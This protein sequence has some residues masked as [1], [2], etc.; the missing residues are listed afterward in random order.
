MLR[1]QTQRHGT[2]STQ[3]PS[4]YDWRTFY[5]HLFDQLKGRYEKFLD[6]L[7]AYFKEQHIQKQ[8]DF[9]RNEDWMNDEL[10]LFSENLMHVDRLK[11]SFSKQEFYNA[12]RY[13][14]LSFGSLQE[15]FTFRSPAAREAH[16]TQ[17]FRQLSAYSVPVPYNRYNSPAIM[18]WEGQMAAMLG[19]NQAGI[20]VQACSSGQSAYSLIQEYLFTVW[21]PQKAQNSE[22]RFGIPHYIYFENEQRLLRHTE[23]HPQAKLVKPTED[24]H[25]TDVIVEWVLKYRPNVLFM[26]PITNTKDLRMTNI[27]AI[28]TQLDSLV[29]WPMAI[30]IDGTLSSGCFTPFAQKWVNL[31]VFYFE[32]C[33]KYPQ[34]GMDFTMAGFLASNVLDAKNWD[35]LRTQTGAVLYDA[36]AFRFPYCNREWHL[37]RMSF[38]EKQALELVGLV[39]GS[40][41]SKSMKLVHPGDSKHADFGNQNALHSTGG[42]LT[43]R[44]EQTEHQNMEFYD[45]FISVMLRYATEMNLAITQGVS[46]GF[47]IP[48]ISRAAAMAGTINPFLRLWIGEVSD[49]EVQK[50]FL[51]I[52]KTCEQLHLV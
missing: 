31:S 16:T 49:E 19:F 34:A 43:F 10:A 37:K 22:W 20:F 18:E 27:S 14:A 46:F 8:D 50:I 51:C 17:S 24:L 15:R 29:D 12:Y 45:L 36:S 32:S 1:T 47:N 23:A 41:L 7:E 48:R 2:A 33:S 25:Q 9:V 13:L 35:L 40:E 26:D 21:L 44:F 42:L 3:S 28:L 11:N 5:E 39:N 52:R 6:S 38:F 30:V 4:S